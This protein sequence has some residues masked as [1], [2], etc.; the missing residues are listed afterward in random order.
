MDKPMEFLSVLSLPL[1]VEAIVYNATHAHIEDIYLH[2][3]LPDQTAQVTITTTIYGCVV[4][5]ASMRVRR[6]VEVVVVRSS[7]CV[8]N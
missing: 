2:I 5:T 6:K 1:S 8:Y 4:L 7:A 3:T